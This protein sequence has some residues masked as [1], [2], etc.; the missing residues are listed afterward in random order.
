MNLSRSEASFE[1]P[2]LEFV[3]AYNSQS[4]RSGELGYGWSHSYEVRV[5]PPSDEQELLYLPATETGFDEAGEVD[6]VRSDGLE[7]WNTGTGVVE[8]VSWPALPP[9]FTQA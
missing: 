1:R 4:D 5:E 3:R 2:A 9:A 8:T 7:T 6:G